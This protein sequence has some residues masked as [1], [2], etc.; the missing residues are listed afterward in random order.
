[1]AAKRRY[2]P[3]ARS[4]NKRTQ[5]TN[6][7]TTKYTGKNSSCFSK[8]FHLVEERGIKHT[9]ANNKPEEC[10]VQKW[11]RVQL[12]KY[13]ELNNATKGK[14]NKPWIQYQIP[15]PWPQASIRGLNQ[16]IRRLTVK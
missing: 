16:V 6:N 13:L 5:Q 8:L 3:V 10:L 7:Q 15:D 12:Q 1:M 4:Y 14:E 2:R 11:R 9:E